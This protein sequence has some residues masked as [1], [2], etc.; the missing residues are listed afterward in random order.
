LAHKALPPPALLVIAA[1]AALANG[2]SFGM[3]SVTLETFYEAAARSMSRSWHNFFFGAVDP[4][5]TVSGDKLP[6]APWIQVLS[7]AVRRA[8]GS[9]TGLV[10]AVVMSVSAVTVLLNRGNISDSVFSR[11][12]LHIGLGLLA[13]NRVHAPGCSRPSALPLSR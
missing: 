12:F 11:V 7:R 6:G 5:G 3:G 2:Y 1:T 9:G 8:A 10:A 13:G 4:W